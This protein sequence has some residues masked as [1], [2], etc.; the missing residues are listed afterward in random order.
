LDLADNTGKRVVTTEK[1]KS[2]W[3]KSVVNALAVFS[4]LVVH[5]F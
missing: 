5:P 3:L 1:A 4:T 2:F